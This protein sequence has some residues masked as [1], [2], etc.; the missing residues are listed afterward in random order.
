MLL[1]ALGYRNGAEDCLMRKK[2]NGFSCDENE[3]EVTEH[4]AEIMNRK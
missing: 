1:R 2:W 3:N 4:E